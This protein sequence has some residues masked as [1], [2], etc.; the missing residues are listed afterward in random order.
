MFLGPLL[1]S[2]EVSSVVGM[3]D[4]LDSVSQPSWCDHPGPEITVIVHQ[5]IELVLAHHRDVASALV[6]GLDEHR[7]F[8]HLLG[9][10]L[11]D[12]IH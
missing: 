2:G 8:L 6:E 3:Q 10:A 12:G 7:A 1:H 4:L 9:E 5:E 11:P